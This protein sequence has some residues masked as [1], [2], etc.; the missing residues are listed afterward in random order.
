MAHITALFVTENGS[1]PMR[2]VSDVQAVA[3]RGLL[4]DRYFNGTGYYS[5]YDVCQVTLIASEAIDEINREFGLDLTAGEHRRNIV[6][7]GIDVHD[8]LKH[9]FR[10][11]GAVLEGT[12]PRPPCAHVEQLNEQ[13]GVARAL[14]AGRGGVCADVVEGGEIAVGDEIT[15]IE[16][17]DKTDSIIERLR[18]KT[19]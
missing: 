6:T 2:S 14:K 11:G 19:R 16:K 13:D 8:L 5:P 7:E 10:I 12:R 9:R 4:N 3:D 17:M 15:D 18:S 1:E